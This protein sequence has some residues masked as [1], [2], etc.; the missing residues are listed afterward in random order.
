MELFV[1]RV[2]NRQ[3][4]RAS[5]IQ[6]TLYK[7]LLPVARNKQRR[8]SRAAEWATNLALYAQAI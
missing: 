4:F 1:S 6:E 3:V 7:Q 2:S 5:S 8:A